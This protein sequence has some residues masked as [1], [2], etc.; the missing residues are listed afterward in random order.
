MTEGY[1]RGTSLVYDLWS[2]PKGWRPTHGLKYP[3]SINT[4]SGI[5]MFY[6]YQEH[7]EYISQLFKVPKKEIRTTTHLETSKALPWIQ[8]TKTT[9]E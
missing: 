1:H 6:S 8:I 9:N 4:T 3:T 5:I 2:L 7:H